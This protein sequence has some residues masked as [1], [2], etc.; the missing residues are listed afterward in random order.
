MHLPVSLGHASTAY[1]NARALVRA[2]TQPL[3]RERR[4]RYLPNELQELPK[5]RNRI[6]GTAAANFAGWLKDA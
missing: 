4:L 5:A 6:S 3:G 1:T 2:R